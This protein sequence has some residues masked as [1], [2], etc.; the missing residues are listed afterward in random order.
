M[1]KHLL[2]P[3]DD[4]FIKCVVCEQTF[5]G[6]PNAVGNRCPGVKVYRWGAWG[7][8]LTKKQMDEAGY[9]TGKHLPAPSGCCLRDKSP[10]GIMWLYDPAQAVPKQAM[11]DAQRAALAK[12]QEQAAPVVIICSRCGDYMGLVTTKQRAELGDD[13]V[14]EQCEKNEYVRIEACHDAAHWLSEKKLRI[15]DTETTGLDGEIVQIAIIDRDSNVLLDTL[16]KPT[17]AIPPDA[18][19]IHG[20]TNEMV[21]DAAT[22]AEIA[23]QV[24]SLLRGCFVVSYNVDFDMAMLENSLRAH[25]LPG[26]LPDD[27]GSNCAMELYAEYCGEWSKYHKSYRWQKLP[28]GDHSALGDARACLNLLRRMADEAKAL[29][30]G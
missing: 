2:S 15:F 8:L 20:I 30:G 19:A 5:K 14:C 23:D 27:M 21:E 3:R 24:L 9:N 17:K 28:G 12:A 25:G 7:N 6:D 4:G 10:G 18:T 1:T 29:G 11:S 16:V 26:L 13:I 22:F